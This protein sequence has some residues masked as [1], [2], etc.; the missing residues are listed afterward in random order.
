M[1]RICVASLYFTSRNS[2]ATIGRLRALLSFR[3][4]RRVRI[5]LVAP[6]MAAVAPRTPAA[7]PTLAT[8][9]QDQKSPIHEKSIAPPFVSLITS[10]P[11]ARAEVVGDPVQRAHIAEVRAT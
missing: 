11:C 5:P 1:M 6:A 4:W 3:F 8:V 2:A 9:H 7:A 10:M